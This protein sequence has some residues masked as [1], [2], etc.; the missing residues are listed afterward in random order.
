[1]LIALCWL[2][3]SLWSISPFAP[4]LGHEIMETLPVA[5][6]QEYILLLLIFVVGW[7]LMTI[8]MM[9]PT[10]L[11]LI[12][13]FQRLTQ[14]RADHARLTVLLVFGYLSIWMLFGAVAHLGDL[15]VHDV[16]RRTTWLET[17][18][19]VISAILL[20]V[21]GL[22]Q[23]TPL[24]YKCLEKCRSPLSFIVAHWRGRG[25][26]RHAFLLGV[27]H[28]LFCLGC[29]WSL[30]L[31]MFAVS[32]SN[33]AWMLLMGIVMATEKNVPWGRQ[34]SAPLGVA[35]VGFSV[36]LTAGGLHIL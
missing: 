35:L 17:N 19:W 32:A 11:P 23:F 3:L 33:L 6:S 13:M 8:A 14:S 1:M 9:L 36:L 12:L 26:Q 7:T 20:A 29:C 2:T 22:Y 5:L 16:V 4:Y 21:A 24:K 31:L 18:E 34:L 27:H 15:M 25:E 30:M 10:S 28:G